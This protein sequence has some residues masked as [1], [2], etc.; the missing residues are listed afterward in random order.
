MFARYIGVMN[1]KVILLLALLSAA[2]GAK[3]QEFF[4]L[5]E[6]EVRI[7]SILPVFTHQ[8]ELGPHYADSAYEVRIVYPEFIDMSAS[9]VARYGE[10][11]GASLPEL[12]RVEQ[13]VGVERKRGRLAVS[14]V[15]LV[16]RQGR[17]QKLVSFKLELVSRPLSSARRSARAEAQDVRRYAAHSVLSQGTWAKIRVSETGIHQ[18]TDAL[19][20]KAGFSDPSKVKVYGYGG[21]LQPETL[22]GDYLAATD[23]LK[24]VPTLT[25][26]GRR[27]FYAVGPVTWSSPATAVRTRN[28]CSDYGYYFLTESDA[29]PLTVDSLAFAQAYYPSN[30]DYHSL[31]EQ[32]GYAWY[33]SGRN[34]YNATALSKNKTQAFELESPSKSGQLVVSMSYNGYCSAA[35]LLNGQA[36]GAGTG[37]S[38]KEAEQ[39]AAKAAVEKMGHE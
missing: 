8:F 16:E 28:Y 32:D 37:H 35:V 39:A 3:S 14:F 24:E 29:E 10:L 23:D 36:I 30:G 33:H 1:R 19:I 22:T 6:E 26:G 13:Y 25:V 9:D 11:S 4:N 27:L 38:K 20:R 34:L 5:T 2:T 31:A 12:P 15:P 18:L 21:A 7:D 17:L